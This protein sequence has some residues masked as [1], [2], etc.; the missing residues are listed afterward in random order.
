MCRG[1]RFE[2]SISRSLEE[3]SLIKYVVILFIFFSSFFLKVGWLVGDNKKDF[4][5]KVRCVGE[6]DSE[7]RNLEV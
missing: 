3:I 4:L 7:V 6:G 1:R 5:K 2:S